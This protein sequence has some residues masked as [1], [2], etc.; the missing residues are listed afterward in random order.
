MRIGITVLSV[1]REVRSIFNSI[2]HRMSWH[3]FVYMQNVS[4]PHDDYQPDQQKYAAHPSK[5]GYLILV[6][7]LSKVYFE[8][9]TGVRILTRQTHLEELSE[10]NKDKGDIGSLELGGEEAVER[11]LRGLK[12]VTQRENWED[13]VE[14]E[15]AEGGLY[16]SR[17]E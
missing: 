6:T 3:V 13:E 16:V 9:L 10:S 17:R 8:S 15:T 12:G 7:N 2:S 1:A 14:L 5:P 11:V 4:H